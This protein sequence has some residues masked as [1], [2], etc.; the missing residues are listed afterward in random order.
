MKS[1]DTLIRLRKHELDVARRALVELEE[2]ADEIAA[3]LRALDDEFAAET[4]R[5]RGDVEASFAIGDYITA[6]RQRK[7][8]IEREEAAVAQEVALAEAR[9][10]DAFRELKR[11]ELVAAQQRDRALKAAQRHEQNQLDEIALT[12]FRRERADQA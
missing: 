5:A 8:A 7:H 12:C 1:V 11:F 6:T 3:R 9:V 2:R 4:A 10:R